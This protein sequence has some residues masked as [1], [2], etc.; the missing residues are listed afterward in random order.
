MKIGFKD[1]RGGFYQVEVNSEDEIPGWTKSL[2]RLSETE[3]LAMI[4]AVAEVVPKVVSMRQA[5]LALLAAGKLGAIDD[6]VQQIG[7]AALIEWEYATEVRRDSPLV[8]QISVALE[9]S[10]EYLDALFIQ[11]AQL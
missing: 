5:R 3:R 9:M 8:N 7:G 11:A 1:N 10:E 4:V 6:A 2:V